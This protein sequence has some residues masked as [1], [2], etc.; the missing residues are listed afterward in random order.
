[1]MAVS[2]I[3]EWLVVGTKDHFVAGFLQPKAQPAGTTEKVGC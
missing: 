2:P 1:M 3:S